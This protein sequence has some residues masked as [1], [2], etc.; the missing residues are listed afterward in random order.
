LVATT[1]FFAPWIGLLLV[2]FGPPLASLWP[3]SLGPGALTVTPLLLALTAFAW[4]LAALARRRLPSLD[5]PLVAPLGVFIVAIGV[6]AWRAPDVLAATFEVARWIELAVAMVLAASLMANRRHLHSLLAA[7]LAS[8]SLAALIGLRQASAGVGPE[9]FTVLGARA[10]RAFGT[11]GQPN[12]FGGYMNM[13]WPLGAALAAWAVASRVG[14]GWQRRSAG[15]GPESA[16]APLEVAE[17]ASGFV[18]P[19]WLGVAGAVAAGLCAA[20]VLA[21]WSRG[22]WIAAASA[23]A[24]MFVIGL[25]GVMRPPV[26]G[27][28]AALLWLGLAAVSLFTARSATADGIS[29]IARP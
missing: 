28:A 12:P 26:R 8:G 22:A 10:V 24:A 15:R 23:A 17:D 7:L 21:S 20:A 2:A 1:V 19:T 9:A 16:S 14:L 4:L 18:V 29:A 25:I 6:A 13:V 27:R 11:F 3:L 5:M